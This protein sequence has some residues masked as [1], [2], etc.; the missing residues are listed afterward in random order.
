MATSLNKVYIVTIGWFL[1][2]IGSLFLSK[3][4][5]EMLNKLEQIEAVIRG[6]EEK[7]NAKLKEQSRR[8][9]VLANRIF[10]DE[11]RDGGAGQELLSGIPDDADRSERNDSSEGETQLELPWD[12]AMASSSSKD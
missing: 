7:Q 11:L 1:K 2:F 8:I 5:R 6:Q 4:D 9:D 10:T 12:D 3:H